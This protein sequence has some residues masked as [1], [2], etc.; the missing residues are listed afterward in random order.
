M[1]PPG[2]ED[3]QS[4]LSQKKKIVIVVDPYS[5]GCLIAQGKHMVEWVVVVVLSENTILW[6]S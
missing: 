2:A 5:T 3:P 6:T 4:Y 1:L